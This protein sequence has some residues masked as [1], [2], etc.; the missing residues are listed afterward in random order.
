VFGPLAACVYIAG[1]A[2]PFTWDIPLALLSLL[3]IPAILYGFQKRSALRSPLVLPVG[4]FLGATGLS[5]LVSD[6]VGRS[7]RLSAPL[8]PATLLFFLVADH[9][10]GTRDLR[11]LYLTFS[12]V[13]LWLASVVVWAGWGGAAWTLDHWGLR[14]LVLAIGNPILVV[15]NDITLLAVIAP[16]SLALLVHERRGVVG[17]LPALSLL[18]SLAAVCMLRSQVATLTLVATATCL[19][20]LVYTRRQLAF[21]LAAGGAVLGLMALLDGA[22]GFPFIAETGSKWPWSMM[23]R[24]TKWHVAW[25]M[26]LEAPL[27]GQGPHTFALF[28]HQAPWAHNLYFEVLA[29]QGVVGLLAL[30][31][32]LVS[33][34]VMAWKMQRT[35]SHELRIF[36][37]GALAGLGGVCGAALV[38]LTLLRLWVGIML[39]TLLGVIAQLSSVHTEQRRV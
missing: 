12:A 37:A 28:H 14:R 35:A 5:I 13:G 26:S 20:L 36:G 21:G 38:E 27:L 16:L 6:D 39:F 4:V 15:P 17:I 3:S 25:T 8:L 10:A 30:G 11:F 9:F 29:E 23:S 2:H 18:V 1:F 34:L 19:A 7:V 24:I 31:V 32:L 22:L 33:G